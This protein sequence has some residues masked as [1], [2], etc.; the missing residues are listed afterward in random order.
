MKLYVLNNIVNCGSDIYYIDIV[1]ERLH[2]KNETSRFLYGITLDDDEKDLYIS[3]QSVNYK[4]HITYLAIMKYLM[5][6]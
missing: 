4:T 2:L 3:I 1:G 5:R 6:I